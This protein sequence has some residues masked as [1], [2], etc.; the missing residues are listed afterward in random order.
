MT[1]SELLDYLCCVNDDTEIV[2]Y[3]DGKWIDD[4][5]FSENG[6]KIEIN[7]FVQNY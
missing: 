7:I 3:V 6:G 4:F 2:C 5:N 1:K